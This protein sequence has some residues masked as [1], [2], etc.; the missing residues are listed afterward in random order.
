[1]LRELTGSDWR[2]ILQLTSDEIPEVLL[3]R[4]T[5][6][7]RRHYLAYAALCEDVRELGSPNALFEDVFVGL[8]NDRRVGYASVYGPA[9]ASEMTHV[10]GMMG[11]RVVVQT[12]VCGA[13]A[14]NLRAGDVVVASQAGCGDGAVSCYLP[15]RKFVDASARLVDLVSADCDPQSF[16]L[17]SVW[18]TP[19]LLAEGKNDLERWAEAGSVA[20]DMETATTYGVAEWT[21]M[22]RISV[23]SVFDNPTIGE[24]LGLDE[25]SKH[26]MRQAG[27]K[28][29]LDIVLNVLRS[30]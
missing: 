7:L 16:T 9:M 29:V 11:T 14:G 8:L 2:S 15:D 24:H 27:E 25:H 20:V 30:A 22:E 13:L 1:M 23:L 4:G 19:A 28:R 5:R 12:G 26:D 21:D 18:T 17:G 3:L 6:N 10:F